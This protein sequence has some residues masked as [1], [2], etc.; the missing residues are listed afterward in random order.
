M[1]AILLPRTANAEREQ[2][3]D[4][5]STTECSEC[6]RVNAMTTRVCPRCGTRS[7]QCQYDG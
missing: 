3:L 7:P 1:V 5:T 6:G 2:R 4:H